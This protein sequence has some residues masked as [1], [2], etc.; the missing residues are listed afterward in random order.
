MTPLATLASIKPMRTSATHTFGP[1]ANMRTDLEKG[2][3]PSCVPCQHNKSS[4]K[5]PTGPLH[6]LPFPDE[7]CESVSMDFIGP[8]PTDR[9]HNCIL[10]ITNRL[11]SDIRIIPTSTSLTARELAILFF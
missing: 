10:T 2:Y 5:K 9:G 8:L 7:R 4:T 11:G 1:R 6:P 3:I